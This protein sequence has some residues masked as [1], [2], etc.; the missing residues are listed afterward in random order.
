MGKKNE[1]KGLTLIEMLVSIFIISLI[2]LTFL[3]YSRS[4]ESLNNLNRYLQKLSNDLKEARN[5][6]LNMKDL[7]D[8]TAR[9]FIYCGW[10]IHFDKNNNEYFLFKDKCTSSHRGNRVYDSSDMKLPSFKIS[11]GV[12]LETNINDLVFEPPQPNVCINGNCSSSGGEIY[13]RAY[14]FLSKII[15]NPIGLISFEYVQ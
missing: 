13:L 3:S 7:I 11:Q 2:T 5:N 1:L 15:I 14:N 8:V 10:G 6:A 9:K 12:V 4:Q